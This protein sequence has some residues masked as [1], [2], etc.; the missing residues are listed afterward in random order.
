DQ[1]AKLF[2]YLQLLHK[3]NKT[4]NLSAIQRPEALLIHIIGESLT[5]ARYIQGQR[6]IDVGTGAGTPGLILA[7]LYPEREFELLDSNG[8][9]AR[10]LLQTC[11]E[12][13][14]RNVKIQQMRVE[15]Y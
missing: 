6:I 11:Y 15:T 14:L 13:G 8:K 5:A 1:Q 2:H 10:F 4:Y 9:K 3:W 7:I 12:I